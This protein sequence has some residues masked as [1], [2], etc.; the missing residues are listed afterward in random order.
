LCQVLSDINTLTEVDVVQ[1]NKRFVLR[2]NVKGVCG[3]AFSVVG[4]AM[5][6]TIRQ[7]EGCGAQDW[8]G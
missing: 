6:P 4:V 2:S 8:L 3:R 1:D 5:P 7:V